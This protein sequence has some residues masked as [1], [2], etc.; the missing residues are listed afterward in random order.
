MRGLKSN[1]I[2]KKEIKII[3][4]AMEEKFSQVYSVTLFNNINKNEITRKDLVQFIQENNLKKVT[5]HYIG[6]DGKLKE[7]KLP[8]SNTYQLEKILTD[9]E[10]ADGCS[11]YQ[12]M[13]DMGKSDVYVV[14]IYKTVF[15]NPFESD[16]IDFICRYVDNDGNLA[17]FSYDSVLHKAVNLFRKKTGFEL[18]AAGELE[19]FLLWDLER[20]IYPIP[21]QMGYHGSIPFTKSGNILSEILDHMER[22][23]GAVK[24]A[25][26]EV[27]NLDGLPSDNEEI[28]NKHMEQLEVEFLPMPIEDMA[29]HM[30]LGKWLIRNIAYKYGCIAT[31]TPKLEEGIAGNAL[32]FHLMIK[33]K[34]NNNLLI[35]EKGSY[36]DVSKKL[37]GGL[38]E[39]A[40][41]LTSFGNTIASSYFRLVPNQEAPTHICWSES[42]R[43]AMIRVPLGWS[44]VDN[45][46]SIINPQQKASLNKKKD[47]RQTIEFRPP[48]GS[49][50]IHLLLAGIT[51]AAEYGLS[52]I[53]NFK[54]VEELHVTG[55]IFQ[56]EKTRKKLK[57]L[58]V[59]CK[60]S[61]EVLSEKRHLYERENIFPDFMIDRVIKILQDENDGDLRNKLKNMTA[62]ERSIELRKILHKDIHSR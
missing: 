54:Q 20:N 28:K 29:N 23:T 2:S 60:E 46:A 7:L 48:D 16:S 30:I 35:D 57:S 9:G 26:S 62:E 8:F 32:H 22:I 17:L 34:E 3:G 14:P 15:L 52:N 31:F 59:N 58:P 19:F 42:N 37:I 53:T 47:I 55:N 25:H 21:E 50:F 12:N 43:S 27:G 39:Y 24:Y 4:G 36:T 45:L 38:I 49:A 13:V 51:M 5:F 56:D 6:G 10:R 18:F 44:K 11:L 1:L 61:S 40:D 33:D 41:S